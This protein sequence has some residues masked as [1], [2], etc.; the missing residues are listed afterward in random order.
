M[1]SVVKLLAGVGLLVPGVL[2]S[3]RG[4]QLAP[5]GLEAITRFLFGGARPSV[6]VTTVL[7]LA[8]GFLLFSA[9]KP[10][11]QGQR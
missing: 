9:L 5:P 11:D 7:V 6:G 10:A 1:H 3:L 8:G 2:L 4:L